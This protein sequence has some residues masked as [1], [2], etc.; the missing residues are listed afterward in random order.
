MA[1]TAKLAYVH[2]KGSRQAPMLCLISGWAFV[3]DLLQ[4]FVSD[5]PL[6]WSYC[7]SEDEAMELPLLLRD[8]AIPVHALRRS[9]NPRLDPPL[10]LS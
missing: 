6:P 1:R 10:H 8:D 3:S 2:Q 5:G 7:S 9:R 4:A